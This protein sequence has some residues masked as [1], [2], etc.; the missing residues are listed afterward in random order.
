MEVTSEVMPGV[1]R[2]FTGF[3]AAAE[4][5]TMSRIYAGQHFIFDETAG[6]KLGN[7]VAR[8]VFKHFLTSIAS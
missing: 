3:S 1:T 2:S 7:K 4:E 8:F 6:T 5:A